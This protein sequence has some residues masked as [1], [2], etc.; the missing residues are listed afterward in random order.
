DI[1]SI[2]EVIVHLIA[3]I[4]DPKSS[5][6]DLK[7]VIERDPPLSARLIKVANSAYYGFRR[8]I[9]K[10]QEAIVGIG[11]DAVKELSL[12]QKVCELFNAGRSFHGYSRTALWEHSLA[13]AM[14]SKY[15]FMQEFKLHGEK[16]YTAGLLQN[17]GIIIEDQFLSDCFKQ[18]LTVSK[19][20]S[21]NM[22]DCERECIGYDHTT[23]GGALVNDWGFPEE[24]VV[25]IGSH[26]DPGN[27]EESYEKVALTAFVAD[28]YTQRQEIGFCDEP[29]ADEAVFA[30]SLDKLGLQ[31]M[32]L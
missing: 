30:R 31:E 11:F 25:A 23:I 16:V 26:H 10:I 22:R 19:E 14:F 17:M 9:G 24:L 7:N 32:A 12:S 20:K 3:V 13:V 6:T 18:A 15:I 21:S 2:K 1:S 8:Q 5:A 4:N 28:Y 27:V 29:Y